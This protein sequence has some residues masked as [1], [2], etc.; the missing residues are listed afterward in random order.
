MRLAGTDLD[1]SRIGFGTAALGRSLSRHERA[2]VVETA[3]ACGI[4][5]FDTAP[6]YGAGAAEDALGAFASRHR[7]RLTIATKV[8][9]QPPP[10]V[11][12]V[13]ARLVRRPAPGHGGQFRPDEMRRSLH[14]SLRRL[15]TSYVDLLLLHEV[16]AQ[17]VDD[18]LLAAL[19]DVVRLG[20]ARYVGIA[21]TWRESAAL[22]ARDR[23]FPAVVQSSA[24]P[25]P[26]VLEGRGLILHS[27]VAGRTGSPPELLRALA[28]RRPDAMLLFGSRNAQHVRETAAAVL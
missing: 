19:D 14:G 11:R 20:E 4:T 17:A 25:E 6:L 8:G 7:D 3:H 13:A 24:E 5:H 22:L 15:R 23:A 10:L 18:E 28:E 2:R 12:L 16:E 21:T 1:V 27:A 26:P 9:I